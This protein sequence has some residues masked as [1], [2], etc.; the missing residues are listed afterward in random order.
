M[1]EL[2][3]GYLAEVIVKIYF[4]VISKVCGLESICYF[5][6]HQRRTEIKYTPMLS[7]VPPHTCSFVL[8][9][10]R[11]KK[12]YSVFGKKVLLILEDFF[13]FPTISG[14]L[15]NPTFGESPRKQ[16]LFETHAPHK[17]SWG[18]PLPKRKN[19]ATRS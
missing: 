1:Y 14:G 15:K 4:H 19:L 18:N 16:P 5:T 13:S 10:R 6:H 2:H 7:L 11:K 8:L 3:Q 12:N 17:L 9:I